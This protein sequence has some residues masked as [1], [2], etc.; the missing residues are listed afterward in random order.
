MTGGPRP[1]LRCA[2][3]LPAYDVQT[4]RAIEAR[5]LA[6]EP[7]GALMQRAGGAVARW[8]AALAPHARRLWIACGPGGNGGDGLHA[9]AA[10]ARQGRQVLVSLHAEADRL[11]ADA[12]CGLQAAMAAGAR[13]GEAAPAQA[14]DVAVDALLGIGSR[15]QPE[16]RVLAGLQA[17]QGAQTP[18][19]AVDLPTGL[20]ADSGHSDRDAVVRARAT[21][22]LLTLKPGLF[23]GTGRDVAGEIWFDDLGI[24]PQAG[25]L[26]AACVIGPRTWPAIA[27]AGLTHGAHK[28]THGDTVVVGGATGMRGALRLAAHAALGAGAGR[29]HAL[30]L[31]TGAPLH[32]DTRPEV[33]WSPLGALGDLA[34][35][36]DATVVFG[37]G[38][39]RSVEAVLATL[40]GQAQR[41]VLDADALNAVA[42]APAAR[43]MLRSR[44]E[45]GFATVLT[46]HPLEAARLLGCSAAEVQADRLR[47][48]RHLAEEFSATVVLKGSGTAVCTPGLP[49]A[50]NPTGGPALAVGG[51]GDVLAGWLGG[52]WARRRAE[53][54]PP[55][56]LA[57]RVACE[58]VWL[59][60]AA[61][62]GPTAPGSVRALDLIDA[63][64]ALLDEM[65]CQSPTC[66]ARPARPP[67]GAQGN[68][69]RPSVSF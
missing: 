4:S 24:R 10:L 59:H 61:A 52:R 68:L 12:R 28:G 11:S 7:G 16:G 18:V 9:A 29:C 53:P 45:R 69:G 55:A 20:A 66:R 2:Q 15:R 21:L 38:G 42:S 35:W 57:H 56:T 8:V 25:D 48:A 33:L 6:A 44:A 37:C 54:V 26:P 13:V 17:L 49:A 58:V 43:A 39:G 47:A 23:T 64:R 65:E 5:A 19:L 40:L 63:M 27:G 62:Q 3:D 32:D 1:A 22:A 67:E 34:W 36:R 60:G 51:T 31:D 46:P 14:V 41:L 50:L 30:A